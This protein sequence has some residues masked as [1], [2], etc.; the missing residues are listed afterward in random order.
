MRVDRN[1]KHWTDHQR[2]LLAAET[3]FAC[4]YCQILFGSVVRKPRREPTILRLNVDHFM[5]FAWTRRED[6]LLNCV[7]ACQICNGLKQDTIF[8][9]VVNAR[10][11]LDRLWVKAG[12]LVEFIPT[13]SNFEDPAGWARE[14][15]RYL[16]TAGIRMDAE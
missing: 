5:P 15:A 9:S 8:D 4:A 12:Y 16:R 1:T 3:G 14:Y 11:H 2:W 10:R 6:D 13:R 7:A